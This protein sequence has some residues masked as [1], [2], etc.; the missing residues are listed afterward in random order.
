[1]T[2]EAHFTRFGWA[3]ATGT[4]IFDWVLLHDEFLT[5]AGQH[6]IMA[7]WHGAPW[8]VIPLLAVPFAH[9]WFLALLWSATVGDRVLWRA[10]RVLAAVL[11]LSIAVFHALLWD[12]GAAVKR[13]LSRSTAAGTA[14]FT[15]AM[16]AARPRRS[17]SWRP[18]ARASA[19]RGGDEMSAVPASYR[20]SQG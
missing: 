9:I 14:V 11:V 10:G 7:R 20:P 19:R 5:P 1:M 4:M 13:V 16:S 12:S 15:D 17:S 2:V 3:F 8:Y 18:A 6:G